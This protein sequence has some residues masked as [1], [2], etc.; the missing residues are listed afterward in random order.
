MTN[1]P[2][3]NRSAVGE[4]LRVDDYQSPEGLRKWLAVLSIPPAPLRVAGL[5]AVL[6]FFSAQMPGLPALDAYDL[7]AAMD[8]SK[9]VNDRARIVPGEMLLAARTWDESPYKLFYT[10]PG[11]TMHDSAVV[12]EGR[13]TVK[14]KVIFAARVLESY[15][16]PAIDVWTPTVPGTH[17]TTA[18][19]APVRGRSLLPAGGVMAL[20]GNVQLIVPNAALVLRALV[21]G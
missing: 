9:P 10:R 17:Q 12:T 16:A 4:A 7:I 2:T 15:A 13:R 14:F 1:G 21:P 3:I 11:R 20:G 5:T 6:R 18:M 8:L 19:R